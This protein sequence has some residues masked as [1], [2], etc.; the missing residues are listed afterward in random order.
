MTGR[1]PG[2]EMQDTKVI[3]SK[4]ATGGSRKKLKLRINYYTMEGLEVLEL[5]WTQI[6]S[7]AH[8]PGS[9]VLQETR[10]IN[11]VSDEGPRGQG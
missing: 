11:L 2:S 10:L 3:V 8:A 6:I 9:I 1:L 5:K 4:N 7:S